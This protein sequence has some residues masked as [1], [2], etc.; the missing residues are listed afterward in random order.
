M[1]RRQPSTQY[2]EAVGLRDL[3]SIGVPQRRP[4]AIKLRK[5]LVVAVLIGLF[6]EF[7]GL[8]H[9]RMQYNFTG[10]YEDPIIHDATYWSIT[11]SRY[12]TRLDMD[13]TG[14]PVVALF[15][16]DES[17]MTYTSRAVTTIWDQIS[18]LTKETP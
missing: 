18:T 5:F 3:G 17:L 15:K 4:G 12:V 10:S 9:L 7:L 11:G 16:L 8:P 1:F 6:V 14:F 13:L 2:E